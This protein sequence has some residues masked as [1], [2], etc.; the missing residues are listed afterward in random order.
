MLLAAC[1]G[2]LEHVSE[3]L[4]GMNVVFTVGANGLRIARNKGN[5]TTG[6]LD[7]AALEAKFAGRGTVLEAFVAAYDVLERIVERVPSRD[8]R[9]AFAN[10]TRWF[11]A[12]VVY[13]RF[14]NVITYDNSAIIIHDTPVFE[15]AGDGT[16][17]RLQSSPMSRLLSRYA[18]ASSTSSWRTGGAVPVGIK[19]LASGQHAATVRAG[20][21]NVRQTFGLRPSSTL[22]DYMCSGIADAFDVTPAMA[23]ALL[24]RA[25][26]ER[27]APTL[28]DM[29][30]AFPDVEVPSVTAIADVRAALLLRI[31]RIVRSVSAAVLADASSALINDGDRAVQRLAA[32]LD[33]AVATIRGSGDD[34]AMT[35]LRRELE[36]IP[37][38]AVTA[39]IEGIV[40]VYDGKAYKLTGGFQPISTLL[41]VAE[42]LR[43]AD[44]ATR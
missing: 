12:E 28:R 15:V 18:H 34:G 35:V 2:K 40:F 41:R 31:E 11:S 4:D 24:S 22:H 38:G 44:G 10:G 6:G 23:A 25:N 30:D 1:Q 5:I 17:E 19:R 42:E 16:V 26:G 29:A 32:R 27:G 43:G 36:R 37:G 20:L 39:A 33:D 21:R 9:S 7:R 8:V 14:V 3:K 13:A